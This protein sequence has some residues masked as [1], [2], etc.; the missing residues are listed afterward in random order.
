MENKSVLRNILFV[1]ILTIIG[2]LGIMGFSV[3]AADDLTSGKT[4]NQFAQDVWYDGK[5]GT[6]TYINASANDYL[7]KKF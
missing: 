6:N 2:I 5:N 4:I 7:R 1:V 3:M